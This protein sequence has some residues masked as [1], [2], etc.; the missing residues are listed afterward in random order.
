VYPKV[1]TLYS[2]ILKAA[3]LLMSEQLDICS[4]CEKG[5]LEPV[6]EV[7]IEG[8]DPERFRSLSGKRI[9][10]CDNC[11]QRYV[12]VGENQYIRL[13]DS[14]VANADIKH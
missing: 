12:K 4:K 13:E 6:A 8:V 10:Q 2:I 3:R 14:I 9:F 1:K 7:V 11:K 5:F